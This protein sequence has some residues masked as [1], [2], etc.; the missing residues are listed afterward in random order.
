MPNRK[1]NSTLAKFSTTELAK[2]ETKL[3]PCFTMRT[4]VNKRYIDPM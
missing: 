3:V 1:T 2:S 4:H